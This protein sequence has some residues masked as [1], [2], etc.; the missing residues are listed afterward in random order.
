MALQLPGFCVAAFCSSHRHHWHLTKGM[1]FQDL[2]SLT[3]EQVLALLALL[4]LNQLFMLWFMYQDL[5][6]TR[7]ELSQKGIRSYQMGANPE[8]YCSF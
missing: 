8:R 3:S 2:L 4:F 5:K 7:L 1:S 6:T